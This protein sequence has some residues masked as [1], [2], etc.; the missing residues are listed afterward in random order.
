MDA[1]ERMKSCLQPYGLTEA[2]TI[3]GALVANHGALLDSSHASEVLMAAHAHCLMP[4]HGAVH[5]LAWRVEDRPGW[6]HLQIRLS[7][8]MHHLALPAPPDLTASR[9]ELALLGRVHDTSDPFITSP[10]FR[11]IEELTRLDRAAFF[12]QVASD[13]RRCDRLLYDAERLQKNAPWRDWLLGAARASHQGAMDACLKMGASPNGKDANGNTAL[14][15]AARF[16][17]QTLIQRLGDHGARMDARNNEGITPLQVAATHGHDF[18][19]LELMANGADSMV[20]IRSARRE[21]QCEQAA[22]L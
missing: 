7:L 12:E 5:D 15:Y 21:Q 13:C 9:I 19:A 4:I 3:A 14:H 22:Y 16:G 17:H 2:D 1:H 10:V 6:T 8:G 18:C 20:L 11:R